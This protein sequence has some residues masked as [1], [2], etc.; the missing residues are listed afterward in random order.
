MTW[1]DLKQHVEDKGVVDDTEVNFIDVVAI[2]N[3]E[4]VEIV[5]DENGVQI[6]S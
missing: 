1:A 2:D 3:T 4:D 5:L 6:F